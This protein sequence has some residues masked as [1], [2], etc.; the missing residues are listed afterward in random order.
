MFHNKDIRNLGLLGLGRDV[1]GLGHITLKKGVCKKLSKALGVVALPVKTARLVCYFVLTALAVY[2]TF[3]VPHINPIGALL[4]IL[5]PIGTA[6]F[7]ASD[8]VF[9]KGWFQRE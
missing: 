4:A 2:A 3:T 1:A 5:L 7:T 9:L 8:I 6:L